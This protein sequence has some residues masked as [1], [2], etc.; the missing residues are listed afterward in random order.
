[1]QVEQ[2][3]EGD[4]RIEAMLDLYRESFD[5]QCR[6]PEEDL[7][8]DLR[9]EPGR[10]RIDVAIEADRL[11][12][13]VRWRLLDSIRA[14]FIVHLA[15]APAIR[16]C[17]VGSHLLAYPEIVYPGLPTIFEVEHL[18]HHDPEEK[19]NECAQRLR[20]FKRRGAKLITPSYT[21]PALHPT[22]DD[23][24]LNL[25]ALRQELIKNPKDVVQGF[26]QQVWGRGPDDPLVLKAL[27]GIAPRGT[28]PI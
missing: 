19:Q 6:D 28:D 23:V 4:P 17:G 12:G 18:A 16:E 15:V 20:W 7:W 26:Y 24:P 11:L 22:T 9:G 8:C 25:L 2:L 14:T 10:Y 1:M 3:V 27:K 13:M 21:Q 5:L